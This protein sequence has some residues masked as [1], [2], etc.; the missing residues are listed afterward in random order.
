M[1]SYVLLTPILLHSYHKVL[2]EL[3]E[4]IRKGGDL[5][6]ILPRERER[7]LQRL[8]IDKYSCRFMVNEHGLHKLVMH[9]YVNCGLAKI[10]V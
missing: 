6:Y 5:I 2:K 8:T 3:S 7:Y 4:D 1:G 10:H 9:L